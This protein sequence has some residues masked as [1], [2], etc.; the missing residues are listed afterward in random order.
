MADMS[1]LDLETGEPFPGT[2]GSPYLKVNDNK[3]LVAWESKF[4]KSGNP[5][6]SITTCDD[7]R[8]WPAGTSVT[9]TSPIRCGV[10]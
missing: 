7:P 3:I 8:T 1:S 5:R 10:P 4:C 6:Y 9:V 2:A